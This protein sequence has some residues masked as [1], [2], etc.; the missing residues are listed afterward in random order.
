MKKQILF[1]LLFCTLLSPLFAQDFPAKPDRLVN[2]YT[3]T[4]SS[5]ETEQLER[6][7][8]AFDDSTS[9]Q[10]AVVLM[11]SVGGYDIS[12]YAARLAEQWGV[13]RGKKNNGVILLAA[14]DDRKVTIQTGYGVEGALPDAIAKRIIENELKPGFREGNY[15][16]GLDRA[17]DA[18]IAYTK[19]EYTN[20]EPKRRKGSGG[21]PI[22]LIIL[23]VAIVILLGRRGG[24]GGGGGRVIGG[25]GG[26]DIF[27]W[28]LLSG[29]G[30]GG[31]RD[32]GGFGGGF[33]GDGGGFGGF[34]GGRFGGGGASGSW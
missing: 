10:V 21:F 3:N 20:D 6:K 33:G 8:V 17:T 14:L 28:T 12:D 29:M 2:D 27:W 16:K 15:Y 1:I 11:R 23:I 31:G 22:G 5:E 25:R 13:G 24:G 34:G 4:L 26:A 32:S 18:I 9:T 30:R 19:G 7:L